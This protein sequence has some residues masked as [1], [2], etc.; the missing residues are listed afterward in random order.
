MAAPPKREDTVAGG[1]ASAGDWM[2]V[3]TD[4]SGTHHSMSRG[5]PVGP[6]VGQGRV[7]GTA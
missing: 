5:R 7:A 1:L 3:E 6:W 4:G 2:M